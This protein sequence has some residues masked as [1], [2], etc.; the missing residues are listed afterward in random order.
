MGEQTQIKTEFVFDPMLAENLLTNTYIIV[1]HIHLR[2]IFIKN[3]FKFQQLME[4][5]TGQVDNTT[6]KNLM[7]PRH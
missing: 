4:E 2:D 3:K 1:W 6:G 5:T 7:L